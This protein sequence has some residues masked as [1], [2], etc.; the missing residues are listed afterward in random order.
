[1]KTA[2]Q[3]AQLVGNYL[4]GQQHSLSTLVER[5][6]SK[7][8][9]FIY[10]KVQNSDLASDLVQDTFLKIIK[11]LKS[12]GYSEEGKFLPWA[13]RIA[14]NLVIDHFRGL[15]RM[16]MQYERKEY[17]LFSSMTDSELTKEEGMI[18]EHIELH[19]H[20]IIKRLPKD[21]LEVVTLRIFKEMSFKEISEQTGVS[22]NTALGRM[23]YALINM[24]KIAS[25]NH[26]DLLA[27]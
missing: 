26:I 4:L 20:K 10:S 5:H 3:D 24:R 12:G 18:Q 22:I 2:T 8:Y 19:L 7:L 16:P 27:S 17:S 11:T 23:R 9:R 6:H 25:E 15:K 13:M 14:H 21:Q 1:M